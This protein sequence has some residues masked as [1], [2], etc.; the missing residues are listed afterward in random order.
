MAFRSDGTGWVCGDGSRTAKPARG[1]THVVLGQPM[2][3]GTLRFSEDGGG[4]W[5]RNPLPTNFEIACVAW[6]GVS[7]IAG[8]S[9]GSGHLDGDLFIC[10]A[11]SNCAMRTMFRSIF[12]VAPFGD[13]RWIAVGAP[14]SVQVTPAPPSPLY[15]QQAC[16]AFWSR[17]GGDNWVPAKGSDAKGGRCLRGLAVKSGVRALAVGDRGDVLTSTDSGETWTAVASGVTGDLTAV[18]WGRKQTAVAVGRKGLVLVSDDDGSTWRRFDAGTTDDLR[19]V[20]AA[21]SRFVAVGGKGLA[22]SLTPTP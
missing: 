14:V 19:A 9:G 7:A 17:D 4:T 3:P 22:L 20:A 10:S 12:G 16:R 6:D 5:R 1:L 18:T 2:V 15:I 11:P 13:G 21:G 8:T